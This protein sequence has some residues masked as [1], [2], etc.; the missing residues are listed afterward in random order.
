[1]NPARY[2]NIFFF[3]ANRVVSYVKDWNINSGERSCKD[4]VLD[5]IR[6]QFGYVIKHL[7]E[8]IGDAI[9][10]HNFIILFFKFVVKA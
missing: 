4:M 3:L 5:E 10:K 6:R 1:M 2:K 8:S 9:G 7:A